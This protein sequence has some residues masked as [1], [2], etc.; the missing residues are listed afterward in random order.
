[1]KVQR[2]AIL[3]MMFLTCDIFAQE[4]TL[5]ELLDLESKVTKAKLNQ[6]L[7]KIEPV[8]VPKPVD[9]PKLDTVPKK[10]PVIEPVTVA[11][12]GISPNYKAQMDFGGKIVTVRK[13]L[14]IYGKR[15][16]SIT[17]EGVTLESVPS[18]SPVSTAKKSVSKK[19]YKNQQKPVQPVTTFYPISA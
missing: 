9:L 3:L 18:V 13:G 7:A 8:V 19:K 14:S 17:A 11:V 10:Q 12:Y 16:V 2:F 4:T 5:G 1:M 6:D 15:V